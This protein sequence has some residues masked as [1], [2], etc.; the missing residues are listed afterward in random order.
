MVASIVLMLLK[1]IAGKIG[2]ELHLHGELEKAREAGRI[3]G[4]AESIVVASKEKEQTIV[5]DK[6][7]PSLE[8]LNQAFGKKP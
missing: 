7:T 2:Y 6:H 8:E 4:R 5:A 3:E 1:F